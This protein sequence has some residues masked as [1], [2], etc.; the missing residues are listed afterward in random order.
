MD[1]ITT[2]WRGRTK[3]PYP[4]E[5]ELPPRNIVGVVAA[6]ANRLLVVLSEE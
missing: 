3:S 2:N 5:V 6:L 4:P 1:Q